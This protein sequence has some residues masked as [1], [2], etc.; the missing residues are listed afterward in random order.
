V[1]RIVRHRHMTNAHGTSAFASN[2]DLVS[3][4]A[5]ASD[6]LPRRVAKRRP[7]VMEEGVV[8]NEEENRSAD[9]DPSLRARPRD[10]HL[11]LPPLRTSCLRLA[12]RPSFMSW[13]LSVGMRYQRPKEDG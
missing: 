3:L 9:V 8:A 5:L 12:A 6:A 4:N 7:E 11:P 13:L 1:Q 10:L 2:K